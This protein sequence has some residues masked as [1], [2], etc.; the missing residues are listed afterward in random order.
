[1]RRRSRGPRERR[2]SGLRPWR[3]ASDLARKA[4]DL[5]QEESDLMQKKRDLRQAKSYLRQK[6]N[7]LEAAMRQ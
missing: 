2:A 5:M 1:M 3:T 6:I 7:D 4:S